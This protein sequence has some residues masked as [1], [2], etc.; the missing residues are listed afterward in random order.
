MHHWAGFVVAALCLLSVNATLQAQG[1][2]HL[3]I[4]SGQSNMVGLK[5]RVSFTPR[6]HE[7]LAPDEVLVVKSAKGGRPIHRWYKKW[8][9]PKGQNGPPNERGGLYDILMKKVRGALDGRT[10]DTITFVW[11]QGE[12]DAR[13]GWGDVYAQSLKGVIQQLRS[14]MGRK[15]INVVIGRL[16]DFS[17]GNTRY[18]HWDQVRA[19]QVAVAKADP[20]G[21]W[22]NTD[23]LNGQADRLHYTQAGYKELGRRF[24]ERA[25][26]L[27][28]KH[29]KQADASLP[30]A[31]AAEPQPAKW[32]QRW[33]MPRHKSK[34][35]EIKQRDQ[36]DLV[37]IGDSITHG[38]ERKHGKP[39]WDQYYGDRHAL[40][41]GFGGDRTEQVIWR[42]RHGEAD[43]YKAELAVIMIGTN[44]AGHRD[45]PPDEVAEGVRVIL[46]EWFKRQP[47]SKALLLGIFPRGATPDNP[48]RQLNEKVNARIKQFVDGKKIFYMDIGGKFLVEDGKLPK[49]IMP[50]R[51]HPRTQGYRIWA[52]AIEPMV[53]KLMDEK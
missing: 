26:S 48:K 25:T 32:A 28:K 17:N 9:P 13:M 27:L 14:D 49:K 18:K 36:I 11:M 2:L 15:D 38:W 1:D 35:K 10:P 37:F 53:Q 39:V 12:R 51:L 43:D 47:Q 6:V 50:D 19:A 3:F 5:P 21:A 29:G 33:W 42:L 23:D 16:S 20:R 31:L 8:Q 44:N 40:N 45:D 24:A 34:L 22:V 30:P 4:L 7:A 52:K 41:L 46:D